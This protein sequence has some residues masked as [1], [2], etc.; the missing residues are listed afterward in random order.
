MDDVGIV[1][2]REK[3][4]RP[5]YPRS[6]GDGVHLGHEVETVGPK[7]HGGALVLDD[8]VVVRDDGDEHVGEQNDDDEDVETEEDD[9][10][11]VAQIGLGLDLAHERGHDP[12][13][14]V[15]K[16]AVRKEADLVLVVDVRAVR[17]F[18]T[19]DRTVLTV[20][21]EEKLKDLRKG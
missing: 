4:P 1:P 21:H 17:V 20:V 7:D 8:A 2:T 14:R 11:G 10:G 3:G 6:V 9:G 18:L 15:L 19:F 5:P 16:G 12:E 13:E